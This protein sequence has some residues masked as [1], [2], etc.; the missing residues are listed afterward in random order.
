MS[1]TRQLLQTLKR[2]LKLQDKTYR[3]V[4]LAL[5]LSEASVKRLLRPNHIGGL[6]VERLALLANLVD[7]TLAELTQEASHSATRLH[8]LNRSQ[9]QELVSDPK[10]LLVAVC[11]LNHWSYEQILAAYGLS[12]PECQACLLRLDKL[13]LITL[14]PGNRIRLNVAR[15]FDW[16]P[17]GPIHQFFRSTGMQD[18]LA[19]SF[20]EDRAT[21]SFVHGMLTEAALEK[22]VLEL[23]SLRQKFAE[24]HQESLASPLPKRRG[25]GLLLALRE[26]EPE[27]FA[28]LRK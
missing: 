6:S 7:M 4:A 20:S 28:A 21:L 19:S 11:A 23:R 9:E 3:D 16:L 24:L 22:M 8:T 25:S 13:Q 5:D 26:W 15:D 14:L 27:H 12:E 2:R 10:L 18:F 1:E 17:S